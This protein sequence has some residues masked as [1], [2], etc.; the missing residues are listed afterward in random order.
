MTLPSYT[1]HEPYDIVL[2]DGP[3]GYPFPDFEYMLFYPHIKKGGLLVVD[4]VN[5]PTI[6][7]LADFLAE[8]EMWEVVGLVH[9]TALFRRTQAETLDPTGD[10]WWTQRYNRRRVSPKCDIYLND[11]SIEDRFTKPEL[12]RKTHGG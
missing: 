10:G 2:I 7:R 3:H 12:D 9:S 4:D 6:G 11:G 1:Q 5:I 8:D